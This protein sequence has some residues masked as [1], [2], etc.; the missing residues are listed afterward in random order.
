[1]PAVDGRIR[2]WPLVL[3]VVGL[4]VLAGATTA[5]YLAMR[6]VMAIGGSCASGG[7]YEVATPCPEGTAALMVGGIFG[8]FIG[9]G[10]TLVAGSELPGDYGS[11]ALLAWPGLF[12]SL[13]WNFLDFGLDPADGSGTN[14]GLLFCGVLFILMGG[15]P[16]VFGLKALARALWPPSRP[17]DDA[18][19]ARLSDQVRAATSR[20]RP[21]PVAARR[22]APRAAAAPPPRPTPQD[23]VPVDAAPVDADAGPAAAD[24]IARELE[25][26]ADLH[27][28]G[29]LDDDEFERAKGILLGSREE[30]R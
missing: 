10:L 18:R 27:D 21:G 24:D 14:G 12:L 26:L 9:A 30:S 1:M 5:T 13:G 4:I 2:V 15:V 19:S 29:A 6:D 3:Y 20:T 23:A 8:W 17:P 22:K 28:R 25:R 7:P 16:L 11:L